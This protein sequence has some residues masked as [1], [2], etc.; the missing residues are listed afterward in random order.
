[1]TQ[2]ETS[3]NMQIIAL[4]HQ[5]EMFQEENIKRSKD[6]DAIHVLATHKIFAIY[7]FYLFIC[8]YIYLVF[9]QLYENE[10]L[11]V[12]EMLILC[13]NRRNTKHFA[14]PISI[15]HFC[16]FSSKSIY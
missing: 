10:S 12:F 14:K 2:E 1:M 6:Y 13:L 3:Y 16:D 9:V 11:T 8:I 15:Q 4:R 7:I 5:I